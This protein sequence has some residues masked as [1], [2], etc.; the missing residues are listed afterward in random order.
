M[1]GKERPQSVDPFAFTEHE[2]LY[3]CISDGRF[4][5]MIEDEATSIHKMEIAANSYGE[6]VFITLSREASGERGMVTM[7][8]LGYHEHRERWIID[9][10]RWYR[11][12]Q[13]LTTLEQQVTHEE[14][15]ELLA[16]RREEIAPYV[17]DESQTPS[18]KLFEMFADLLDED[19]AL[20]E[21]DDLESLFDDFDD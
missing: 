14:A 6:F 7:W 9:H 13:S 3:D 4:N 11:A 8:G 1:M 2:Q 18:G 20:A 12:T 16:Q 17:S 15:Q 5:E 21:M 10:W 19:G